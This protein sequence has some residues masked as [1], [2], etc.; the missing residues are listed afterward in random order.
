M[1]TWTSVTTTIAPSWYILAHAR[2]LTSQGATRP[3]YFLDKPDLYSRDD[4]ASFDRHIRYVACGDNYWVKL[5]G[6]PGTV[7]QRQLVNLKVARSFNTDDWFLHIDS[8]EFVHLEQ[9]LEELVS[10]LPLDVTEI[11]LQNFERVMRP[12]ASTWHTGAF[13]VPSWDKAALSNYPELIQPFLGLG[14]ANY[15]HGKSFVKQ[16]P[17][18]IQGIHGAIRKSEFEVIRFNVPW[19]SGF[20]GHYQYSGRESFYR[21]F[22][23]KRA[24]G[25]ALLKH[26]AAQADWIVENDFA[27]DK[28][29]QLATSLFEV[30][31][32]VAGDY[33]KKGLFR[34]IPKAFIE[35]LESSFDAKHLRVVD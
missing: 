29:I 6:K 10:V 32:V 26:E 12:N 11:R 19:E 17:G 28:I 16:V 31:E 35:R 23:Y 7:P 4:F 13:R 34:D 25:E 9:P 1:L 3:I 22:S 5:K 20:V 15:Y 18:L 21:R 33:V 14:M 27:R 24:D 30:D 2:H 8:D